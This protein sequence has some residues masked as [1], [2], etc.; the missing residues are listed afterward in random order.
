M[1][2]ALSALSSLHDLFC[3]SFK[4]VSINYSKI[5]SEPQYRVIADTLVG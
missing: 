1:L 3:F 4:A 5:Y 2:E